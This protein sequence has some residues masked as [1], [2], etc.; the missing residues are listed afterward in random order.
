MTA[1]RRA[2]LQPADVLVF[3]LFLGV[4]L[5]ATPRLWDQFTTAKWY[6]L[7]L[8]AASWLAVEGF[9]G[10]WRWP[11]FLRR[12]WP[13]AAMVLVLPLLAVMRAG[14]AFAL[15]PLVERASV[16]ALVFCFYR[17]ASRRRQALTW[18]ARGTAAAALVTNAVLSAQILGADPLRS[19]TASDGRSAL[20]GNANMA[21]QFLGGACLL[22]LAAR[23]PAAPWA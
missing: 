7:E 23:R 21:A 2:R 11:G 14:W 13:F 6:L 10:P 8:L 3:L 20:F 9:A 22:L 12:W 17:Y 4:P 1:P 15:T 5:A 18:P 16:G 19:L